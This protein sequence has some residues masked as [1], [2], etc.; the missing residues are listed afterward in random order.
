MLGLS[1]TDGLEQ[2]T[3]AQSVCHRFG[4]FWVQTAQ[5]LIV[6]NSN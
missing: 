2:L 3:P 6:T 5:L 1:L 4:L